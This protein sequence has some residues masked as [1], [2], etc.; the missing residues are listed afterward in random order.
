MRLFRRSNERNTLIPSNAYPRL[1]T[2]DRHDHYH[3]HNYYSCKAI[4]VA[5]TSILTTSLAW[6]WGSNWEDTKSCWESFTDSDLC[7]IAKGIAPLMPFYTLVISIAVQVHKKDNRNFSK[8]FKCSTL[9]NPLHTKITFS[10]FHP[11][12][13]LTLIILMCLLVADCGA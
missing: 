1:L 10:C 4:N 7:N 8:S 9:N 12:N 3:H 2:T 6:C 13:C 5:G 11:F